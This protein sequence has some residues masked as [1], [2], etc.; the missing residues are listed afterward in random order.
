MRQVSQFRSDRGQFR[1]VLSH[2]RLGFFFDALS[3]E[4][5]THFREDS[6]IAERKQLGVALEGALQD[7]F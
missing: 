2:P 3:L 1:F 6:W 4:W 7:Y 5:G